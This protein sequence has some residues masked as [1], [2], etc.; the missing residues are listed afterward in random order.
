MYK[1]FNEPNPAKWQALIAEYFPDG[2]AIAE[3]I[4]GGVVFFSDMDSYYAW[5]AAQ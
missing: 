3:V 2:V 5:K 1:Q 4:R